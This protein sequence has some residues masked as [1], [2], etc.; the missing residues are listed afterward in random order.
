MLIRVDGYSKFTIISNTHFE[1][2]EINGSLSL[3]LKSHFNVF[4]PTDFN[5]R[6]NKKNVLKNTI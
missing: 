4:I 6:K 1:L 2:I 3:N 5:S